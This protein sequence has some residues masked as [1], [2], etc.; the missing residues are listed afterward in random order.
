[1]AAE[2]TSPPPGFDVTAAAVRHPS[3]VMSHSSAVLVVGLIGLYAAAGT[4]FAIVFV[5]C[6]VTRIDPAGRGSPWTFRLMIVPGCVIFWPLLLLRWAAG[7]IAP[8]VER[9]AH[10]TTPRHKLRVAGTKVA[11]R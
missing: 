8:P 9:N 4:L 10:R 2:M 5:A 3:R 7:S 6:G 1:M 11:A